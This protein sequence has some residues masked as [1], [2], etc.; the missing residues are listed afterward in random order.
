MKKKEL[1]EVY[2]NLE[3]RFFKQK[4]E[5][6]EL[7]GKVTDLVF[8]AYPCPEGSIQRIEGDCI[9]CIYL[10]KSLGIVIK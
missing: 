4:Q 1:L 6:K 7:K 5:I 8:K 10:D 2:E 9:E 3:N